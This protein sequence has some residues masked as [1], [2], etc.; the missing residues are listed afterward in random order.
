MGMTVA[1]LLTPYIHQKPVW[2]LAAWTIVMAAPAAIPF[3]LPHH[4]KAPPEVVLPNDDP[5][6]LNDNFFESARRS[7]HLP[8]N[9][10]PGSPCE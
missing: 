3:F 9:T 5:I 10:P 2:I 8:F 1:R 7:L 4:A 6:I